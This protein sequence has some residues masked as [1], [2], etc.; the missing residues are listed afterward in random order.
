MAL[1]W[2]LY[3][4]LFALMIAVYGAMGVWSLPKIAALSGGLVPFDLH[5]T[6]YSF[7]QAKIFLTALPPN[8]VLFYLNV[9]QML[10]AAFPAMLAVVLAVG[11]LGLAAR[12]AKWLGV[13]AAG[14]AVFGAMFD[15]LENAAVRNMLLAGP[16][17]VT[18]AMV[19]RAS[20]WTVLKSLFTTVALSIVL[21]LLLWAL[22]QWWQRRSA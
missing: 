2:K 21:M 10:D 19:A 20:Q 6:G 12:R 9:Q 16:D 1:K 15:T 7:D 3:W 18:G 11:A 8:G 13:L 17:G 5:L 4:L 14:T 22:V